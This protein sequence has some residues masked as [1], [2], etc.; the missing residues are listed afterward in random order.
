MAQSASWDTPRLSSSKF[1]ILY[2][3]SSPNITLSNLGE[4]PKA[5]GVGIY[6]SIGKLGHAA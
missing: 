3:Q 1:D 4:V 6:S 5:E 2:V